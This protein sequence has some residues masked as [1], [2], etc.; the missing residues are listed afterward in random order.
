MAHEGKPTILLDGIA[1]EMIYDLGAGAFIYP[2]KSSSF[3]AL[4]CQFYN[5][6]T[7]LSFFAKDQ[8]R[9]G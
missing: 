2:F 8:G 9:K 3:R 5:R 4:L 6:S 7:I 1:G